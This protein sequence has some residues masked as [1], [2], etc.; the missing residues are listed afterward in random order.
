MQYSGLEGLLGMNP[1][2]QEQSPLVVHTPFRQPLGHAG[3]QLL[4][5]SRMYPGKQ[6]QTFGDVQLPLTQ[7]LSQIGSQW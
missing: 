1:A 4:S 5:R 3:M 2:L 7:S 6:T